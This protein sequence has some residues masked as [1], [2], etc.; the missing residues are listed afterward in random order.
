MGL[1]TPFLKKKI[2]ATDLC[3]HG[4]AYVFAFLTADEDRGFIVSSFQ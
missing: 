1:S 2:A 4:W 3:K